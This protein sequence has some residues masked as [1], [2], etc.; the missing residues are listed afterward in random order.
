VIH[1]RYQSQEVDYPHVLVGSTASYLNPNSTGDAS[2][3]SYISDYTVSN[4]HAISLALIGITPLS[5]IVRIL[6]KN[7]WIEQLANDTTQVDMST[8]R[9]FTDSSNGEAV[10]LG[11]N[12]PN[13]LSLIIENYY[14][15]DTHITLAAGNWDSCSLS[16]LDIDGS[17]WGKWTAI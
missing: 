7:I 3:N 13:N 5:N 6:V 14:G 17:Y 10:Q 15:G 11:A 9:V 12:S 1:C 8:F 4:W 16:R 2:T